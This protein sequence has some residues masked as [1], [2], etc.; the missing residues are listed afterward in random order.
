MDCL[1]SLTLPESGTRMTQQLHKPVSETEP[2]WI[3]LEARY[4]TLTHMGSV[5][6]EKRAKA[7]IL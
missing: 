3:H 6:K 4:G 7:I 2:P 5:G 1:S